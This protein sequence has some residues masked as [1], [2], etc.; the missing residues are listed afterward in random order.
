MVRYYI[1]QKVFSWRDRFTV[2]DEQE[3][4]CYYVEGELLTLGKKLRIFTMDNQEA[5]YI[6]QKL[7]RFLPE[8]NL[9]IGNKQLA[10]IKKEF[11]LFR[12]NY[13][14]YGPDWQIEGNFLAHDYVIRERGEVIADI[15][16]KWLSWGDTYEINILDET[17]EDILLG[18]VIV[19]DC[20]ISAQ[21]ASNS[22]S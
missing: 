20:V 11:H 21:R 16:R 8:Y 6:E 4:D 19:I 12:N 1:K 3:R 10:T 22:S 18:A 13:N 9:Y 14:I 7:W 5:V 2:K 17:Q 15:N